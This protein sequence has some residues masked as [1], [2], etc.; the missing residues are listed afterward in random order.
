MG[1]RFAPWVTS[2]VIT[3]KP[4]AKSS[5]LVISAMLVA[6]S[7]LSAV[8]FGQG[9]K[10][11]AGP[12]TYKQVQAIFDKNCINCHKAPKPKAMMNLESYAGLMKG[13]DDGPVIT[14]GHP[15]KSFLYA[16]IAGTGRKKMPPKGP[17]AKADIELIGSWIKAGAKAK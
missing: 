9:A 3:M 12:V 16:L 8:S 1:H 10:K 6:I 14:A 5:V 15:E 13:N 17:L 4:N 11:K 2:R 7:A